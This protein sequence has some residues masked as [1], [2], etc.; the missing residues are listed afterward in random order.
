MVLQKSVSGAILRLLHVERHL[1]QA[2]LATRAMIGASYVARVENGD[3]SPSSKA[4]FRIAQ[5]LGMKPSD[6]VREIELSM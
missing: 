6:I 3:A 4:L 5:G 2:E 1:T